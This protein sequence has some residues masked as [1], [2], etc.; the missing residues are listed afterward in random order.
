MA[1]S[2]LEAQLEDA[3]RAFVAT[4]LGILRNASLAEVAAVDAPVGGESRSGNGRR[5]EPSAKPSGPTFVRRR[6]VRRTSAQ[7]EGLG[8][9]IVDI[10]GQA[11]GPMPAR[12]LADKLGVPLD[13][14]AKP[15]KELRDANTIVKRGEK[16]ASKY[17]LS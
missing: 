4:I 9:K 2:V 3:T 5:P 6:G 17:S 16:R 12:T 13:A 10:L 14:L 15:L 1:R 7:M 11:E 8:A